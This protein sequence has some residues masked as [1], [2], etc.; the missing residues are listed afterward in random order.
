MG[1]DDRK[2][3]N[4]MS[5]KEFLEYAKDLERGGPRAR[6]QAAE[7]IVQIHINTQNEA[8]LRETE[9]IL[10]ELGVD[11]NELRR[12]QKIMEEQSTAGRSEDIQKFLDA[13]KE[14]KI[15]KAR[16]LSRR[17][18]VRDAAKSARSRRGCRI[19][20]LI[21]LVMVSAA[22]WGIYQGVTAI[23]SALF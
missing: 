23:A 8:I 19:F 6:K 14:G 2:P 15:A 18:S 5:R 9:N 11:L 17:K 22:L 7:D 1:D 16:R 21:G 13:I 10:K 3:I 4:K 12:E 20:A